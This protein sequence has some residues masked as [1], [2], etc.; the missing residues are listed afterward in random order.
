ML[1]MMFNTITFSDILCITHQ[2]EI[3]F[4]IADLYNVL[5]HN[6]YANTV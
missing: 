2:C 5:P 3:S 1:V 4:N 6:N